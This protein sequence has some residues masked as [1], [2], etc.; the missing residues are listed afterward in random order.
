MTNMYFQ[1]AS[2]FYMIIILF[3]YFSKK[4][5]KSPETKIFSIMSTVNFIGIIIDILIVYLSYVIPSNISLYFLNKLYL[6]CILVWTSLFCAYTVYVSINERKKLYNVMKK[7]NYIILIISIIIISIL[8]IYP[9]YE[10]N[11]ILYT[12]G[13]SV[14]YLY[15]ITVIYVMMIAFSVILNIKNIQSKK[16][17]PIFVLVFMCIIA[18]IARSIDPRILLTTSI[19]TYITVLMYF[20]IENPDLKMINELN[21]AKEQAEKANLAKTEFLSSMSHEIRTPLNAI[22][23]FSQSLSEADVPPTIKEDLGYI[24][25]ATNNLLELVNGILDISKIEAN[26]LE[27]INTEYN[28]HKLFDEVVALGRG[29]LGEKPLDFRISIDK[30]MPKI[31]YGDHTRLKQIIINLL[32]NAIKYTN[33]GFIDFK[34]SSV[35]KDDMC[36][37]IISVEDSGIGIQEDKIDKLFIK[38]E[39][40]GVEKYNSSEGTGLGLAITKKLVE[41]MNGKIVVQSKYGVG[42]KFTVAIDQKLVSNPDEF[43]S[44]ENT[45]KLDLRELRFDNKKILVVDDNQ[46]NLKVA[47][48]LLSN[49]NVIIEE[50]SSGQECL[51]KINSG[52][53]YDLILLDDMM[54]NMSGVETIHELKKIEGFNIPVVA[55]TANA[56]AGMKEKYL[57]EGFDDY[58]SKPIERDVLNNIIKKF[59]K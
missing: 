29:R 16:Y 2:F 5:I 36:R 26:K 7:I 32:T 59:L 13:P 57:S 25:V 23:G 30:N 39:R 53:R 11:I 24:K 35:V 8:P 46:M 4:R 54:P 56:I 19:M 50:V 27:I 51:D 45:K 48:R 12:F 58:M 42:S 15:I 14:T 1:I 37:L 44:L 43:A 41:L 33:E 17:I 6:L 21:I 3:I 31:L 34:V 49:Y 38:F 47:S 55:L 52:S 18:F 40:A 22:A 10:N 9:Y 28:A 20:T